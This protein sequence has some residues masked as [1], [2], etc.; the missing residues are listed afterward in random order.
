MGILHR[1][2][3]RDPVK[4]RQMEARLL[5]R[6]GY[7]Q[8]PEAV[9][10]ITTSICDL[11]CPHCY[12]HAGKK[13][14]G[15][16]STDEAKRLIIDELVRLERPTLVIAGG[17]ALLRRDFAE[18]VRYAHRC[19]VPWALHS[20]GGWVERE[21]EIFRECPP[22]MV[23]ISLDGPRDYH[24]RFRGKTG[25]HD[26]ALRAMQLLKDAGCP[27]VVAGTTVTRE[28]ADLLAD[29]VPDVLDSAADSWGFHLMTPEGRA[30]EHLELLPTA[31]QLRRVAAFG[32]RLRRV[33]AFG[34]RLVLRA[35][36]SPP[37]RP[38][39]PA[40]R[41]RRQFHRRDGPE[42][43]RLTPCAAALLGPLFRSGVRPRC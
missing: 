4:L 28:N 14:S 19:E 6:L 30:G 18:L 21:I 42:R 11:S 3:K 1:L 7:V 24:D 26:S 41:H 8:P 36:P 10:W 17:E 25:C 35:N 27:E 39:F 38:H 43:G 40:A 31:E 34:L 23:A 15:E 16:L 20:H 9:Q 5:H 2:F 13:T 32:R 33:E 22:V 37:I 29:M 12:S